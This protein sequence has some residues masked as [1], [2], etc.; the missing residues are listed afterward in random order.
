[1]QVTVIKMRRDGVAIRKSSLTDQSEFRGYLT[2][3]ETQ[4]NH[5][6]RIA[7]TARLF[8]DAKCQQPMEALIEPSIV[9]VNEERLMISG[10]EHIRRG[11]SEI[12]YAQSWLC[13]LGWEQSIKTES[14]D[15][16]PKS[17]KRW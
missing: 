13:L 14:E 7:K 10:F 8:K 15:R 4:Q 1:M 6:H 11:E 9:W 16:G 3:N 12:D 2:I 5:L 17:K